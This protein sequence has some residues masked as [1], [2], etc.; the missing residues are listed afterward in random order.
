[1][2]DGSEKCKRQLAFELWNSCVFEKCSNGQGIE[3]LVLF[4]SHFLSK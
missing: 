2:I 3:Q 1:M 4:S